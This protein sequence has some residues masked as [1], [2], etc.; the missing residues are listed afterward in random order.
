[1]SNNLDLDQVAGNQN[2]KEITINDAN[3]QL[4]AAITEQFVADVTS[5]NVTLTDTEYRETI[6]VKVIG[7]T[8]AGRSV[9]F[10]AIKR[11]VVIVSHTDATESVDIIVGS[12]TI[13][14]PATESFFV[15]TDG[16][17]N[18]LIVVGGSG[19]SGSSTYTGLTDT[20]SSFSGEGGKS[21]RVNSG[22]TDIEFVDVSFDVG[23]AFGGVPGTSI[24]IFQF[25]F[26]RSVTF[27]SGLTASQGKAS[28]AATAQTDF[29]LQ[30]NGISF[31]TMRFAA[32]GTTSTFIA[33]SATT[34]VAGDEIKLV[35]PNP[36][37]ATLANLSF[38]FAGTA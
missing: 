14:L 37:D 38:T 5:G 9:T 35:S 4:D 25:L 34:F 11:L 23:G 20:P 21:S 27:P 24:V 2:Q 12:T 13:A 31:G 1:M 22:E 19:G 15:Y 8:N 28:V 3:A 16:T 33:G 6:L 36:A 26:T 7:A 18:G 29:D 17:T 10:P 30:K 32:S